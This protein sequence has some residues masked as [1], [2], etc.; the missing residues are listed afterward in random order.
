[1]LE[2]DV[3]FPGLAKRAESVAGSTN[4]GKDLHLDLRDS[5]NS[6]VY[7]IRPSDANSEISLISYKGRGEMSDIYKDD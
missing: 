5:K 3:P 6:F 2:E 4:G 1:M 7:L